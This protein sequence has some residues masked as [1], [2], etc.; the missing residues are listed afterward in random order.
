MRKS[1]KKF[2]ILMTIVV[3]AVTFTGCQ[4]GSSG[5]DKSEQ[6]ENTVSDEKMCIRDSSKLTKQK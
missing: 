6:T 5:T 2:T 3:L 1:V 4:N